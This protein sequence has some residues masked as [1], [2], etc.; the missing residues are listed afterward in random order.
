MLPLRSE[1]D[2]KRSSRRLLLLGDCRSVILAT[3]QDNAQR[4]LLPEDTRPAERFAIVSM[5]RRSSSRCYQTYEDGS[6]KEDQSLQQC[7]H[8][9]E[10]EALDNSGHG[11]KTERYTSG[12]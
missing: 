7:S 11:L 1:I 2:E 9:D 8:R 6:V 3:L 5:G 12:R 10:A 4:V